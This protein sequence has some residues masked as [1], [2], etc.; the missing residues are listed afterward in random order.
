[1]VYR[2]MKEGMFV[3]VEGMREDIKELFLLPIPKSV[4]K[5]IGPLQERDFARFVDACLDAH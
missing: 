4:W 2:A 5:R 3:Q 1:M